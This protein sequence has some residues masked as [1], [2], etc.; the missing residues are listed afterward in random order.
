MKNISLEFQSQIEPVHQELEA[1]RRTRK[2]REPIPSPIWQAMARL[3][4]VHGIS[5]VCQALRVNYS[6]LK[7]RSNRLAK[8]SLSKAGQPPAF[9]EL[10]VTPPTGVGCVVE[11]EDRGARMT[12]RLP[13]CSG[14]DPVGLL[15]AFWRRGL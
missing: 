14:A 2:H 9:V 4:R 7:R 15:Q 12:L 5:P 11:V 10:N 1:W 6:D 13:A 8:V 3:S